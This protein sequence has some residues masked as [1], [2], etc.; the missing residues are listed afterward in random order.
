MR[1]VSTGA[2]RG[3]ALLSVVLFLT[4]AP[5]LSADDSNPY[6]P[7]AA[8]IRPPVGGNAHQVESPTVM[9]RFFAWLAAGVLPRLG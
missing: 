8:I 5:A 6:Q 1:R 9:Q 7:P 4:L 3:G 2:R